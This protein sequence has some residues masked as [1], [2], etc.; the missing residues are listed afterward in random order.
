MRWAYQRFGCWLIGK[1]IRH[2]RWHNTVLDTG[3]PNVRFLRVKSL[4]VVNGY[5]QEH[6]IK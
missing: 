1:L 2:F 5:G 6:S 4:T 3:V